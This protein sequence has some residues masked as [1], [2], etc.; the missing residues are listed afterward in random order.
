[1]WIYGVRTTDQDYFGFV[2]E[3]CPHGDVRKLLDKTATHL[4]IEDKLLLL[5]DIAEVIA[6]HSF[7][8][9]S[10]PDH[11]YNTVMDL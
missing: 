8:Y 11:P 5:L 7:I 9:P 10:L 1:M 6:H 3:Y 4:R 2:L